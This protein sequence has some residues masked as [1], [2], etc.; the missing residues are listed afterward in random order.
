MPKIAQHWRGGDNIRKA[1][2]EQGSKAAREQGVARQEG[3][4]QGRKAAR[5]EGGQ[6][7]RKAG[8]GNCTIRPLLPFC[9]APLL[10]C[11][12]APLLPFCLAPLLPCCPLLIHYDTVVLYKC[13]VI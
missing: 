10:P 5:Q 2:R 12:L 3:G 4:Q 8:R 6:Q 7:G 1:A 11:C 9:L 13:L